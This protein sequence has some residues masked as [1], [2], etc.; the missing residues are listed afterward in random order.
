V[1]TV[2]YQIHDSS[3]LYLE[4]SGY[5]LNCLICICNYLIKLV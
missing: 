2:V 3:D 4:E 5:P 1:L